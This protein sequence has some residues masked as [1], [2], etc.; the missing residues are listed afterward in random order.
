MSSFKKELSFN[1]YPC[2]IAMLAVNIFVRKLIKV[3]ENE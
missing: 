3:Q 1:F 2:H